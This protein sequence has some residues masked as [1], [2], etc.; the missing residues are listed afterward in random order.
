MCV[1]R[2]RKDL[3]GSIASHQACNHHHGFRI[4]DNETDDQELHVWM[5]A[6]RHCETEVL[7][8]RRPWPPPLA[9]CSPTNQC[10]HNPWVTQLPPRQK[11]I[12]FTSCLFA[13]HD[14]ALPGKKGN[15]R[16]RMKISWNGDRK[17]VTAHDTTR[18]RPLLRVYVLR[19]LL[20]LGI[21]E[22]CLSYTC[23]KC[24]FTSLESVGLHY[25]SS[26]HVYN[27]LPKP[28]CT[29]RGKNTSYIFK[30]ERHIHEYYVALQ[31]HNHDPVLFV[32]T[33]DVTFRMIYIFLCV[34]VCLSCLQE[35]KAVAPDIISLSEEHPR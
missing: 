19:P 7:S 9:Y 16:E 4:S 34:F 33:R 28:N 27:L 31:M 5:Q 20:V 15:E 22:Y 8:T 32:D 21:K 2:K 11:Q 13:K 3:K 6:R 23:R 29:Y 12:Q 17:F 30:E 1:R 26:V 25:S 10:H 18:P 14:D 24:D 35:K